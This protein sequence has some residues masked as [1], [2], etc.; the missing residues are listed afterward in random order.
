[1]PYK[2]KYIVNVHAHWHT[3]RDFEEQLADWTEQGA[4]VTCVLCLSPEWKEG[5]EDYATNDEFRPWLRKYPDRLIGMAAVE[6]AGRVDGADD[7]QRYYD[8]G[9]RGLKMLCPEAP[10]DDPRY[11]AVYERAQS[12]KMPILFHTGFVSGKVGT[13]VYARTHSE[14][15][16]PWYLEHALR[17]FP[18]LRAIGAH[19]GKPHIHEALQLIEKFPNAY[20]DFCGAGAARS[21]QEKI[22]RHLGPRSGVDAT[23]PD[24][25][26]ALRYFR[27][28]CFGTDNPSVAAWHAAA[29]HIMD[30]LEIPDELREGYYWRNAARIFELSQRLDE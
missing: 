22:I 6:V 16:R 9:F 29:E 19:L 8:R 26:A 2:P 4:T 10:Y 21:W 5:G 1:M 27:K 13:K 25:H 20:Y 28:F 24:Q 17:R 18:E 15:M 14:H 30:S 11:H 23:D 7:V 3:Q 12:L